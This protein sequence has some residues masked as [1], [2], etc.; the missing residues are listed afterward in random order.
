M[1]EKVENKT[2]KI[3]HVAIIHFVKEPP[4]YLFLRQLAPSHYQWFK[5]RI[6]GE[7]IATEIGAASVEKA[8]QKARKHWKEASFRTLMCGFRYTLPERDEHGNNALFY[9]MGASYDSSNGVYFDEERG[10]NCV[11]SFASQEARNLWKRL[12]IH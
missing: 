7:E 8:L 6:P 1:E 5:E 11:V 12:Q 3:I 9:Q 2:G 10:N 4:S